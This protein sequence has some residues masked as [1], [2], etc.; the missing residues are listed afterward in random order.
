MVE[1]KVG[2]L[3]KYQLALFFTLLFLDFIEVEHE[4]LVLHH[5][6]EQQLVRVFGGKHLD[7][8]QLLNLM[9]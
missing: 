7:F 3:I 4:L 5:F 6:S 9:H 8:V 2:F 1:G